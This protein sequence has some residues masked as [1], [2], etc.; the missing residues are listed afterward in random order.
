[1]ACEEIVT[2]TLHGLIC[3]EAYGIPVTWVKYSDKICG[4]QLK[5]QDYFLGTGRK[6]QRYFQKTE[7][8]QGLEE[9]Q[10]ELINALK[11]HY[12]K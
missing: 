3:A 12:G 6:E 8:L 4:G 9:R 2:S 5:F 11:K 7:P 10:N 1:M